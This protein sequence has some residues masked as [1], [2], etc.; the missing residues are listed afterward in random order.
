MTVILSSSSDT[1]NNN[2][3]NLIMHKDGNGRLYYRIGLNY[4]PSNLQ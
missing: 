3:K 4:A 2:K 1:N